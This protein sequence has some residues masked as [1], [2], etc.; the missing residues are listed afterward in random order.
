MTDRPVLYGIWL[1]PFMST[2]AHMLIEAGIPFR[3][4]RVSPLIGAQSGPISKIC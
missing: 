2:A 4:E 3:Y 1:S